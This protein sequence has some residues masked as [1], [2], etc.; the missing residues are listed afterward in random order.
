MSFVLQQ[1]HHTY[2]NYD[3]NRLANV[4]VL[5]SVQEAIF[6]EILPSSKYFRQMV[7]LPV[8]WN[9]TEVLFY[10]DT[11]LALSK[12]DL[13]SQKKLIWLQSKLSPKQRFRISLFLSSNSQT[14]RWLFFL[15]PYGYLIRKQ[16]AS[17]VYTPTSWALEESIH[18]QVFCVI[19]R[20]PIKCQDQMT[21]YQKTHPSTLSKI[22]NV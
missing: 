5:N 9:L 21:C 20:I 4:W 14:K 1:K 3:V 12:S 8:R 16:T 22:V 18:F 2:I 10:L 19:C 6:H 17:I 13:K 15:R 11:G 7:S